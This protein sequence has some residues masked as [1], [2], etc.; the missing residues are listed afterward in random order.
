MICVYTYDYHDYDDIFRIREA[1]RQLGYDD[2]LCYKADH[3]TVHGR[4]AHLGDQV[5]TYYN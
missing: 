5:I 4:Y 3:D 1:L 2:P